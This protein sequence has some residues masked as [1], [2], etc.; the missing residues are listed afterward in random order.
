[1]RPKGTTLVAGKDFEIRQVNEQVAHCRRT[2]LRLPSSKATSR[3]ASLQPNFSSRNSAPLLLI[4]NQVLYCVNFRLIQMADLSKCEHQIYQLGS[5]HFNTKHLQIICEWQSR[6]AGT[7]YAQMFITLQTSSFNVYSGQV[8]YILTESLCVSS[9]GWTVR[10]L[11]PSEL[12]TCKKPRQKTSVLYRVWESS[13][14]IQSHII[15][16][17]THPIVVACWR[18]QHTT[19]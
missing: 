14:Q 8:S 15:V 19:T 6:A 10:Y 16:Y 13:H 7:A 11:A 5:R 1:M 9:V 3:P 2:V 12:S 4:L 17:S 18:H